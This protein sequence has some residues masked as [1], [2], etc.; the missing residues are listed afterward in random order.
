MAQ[1][2]AMLHALAGLDP[3]DAV[4]VMVEL[5]RE[6]HESQR[7]WRM[8]W[9]AVVATVLHDEYDQDSPAWRDILRERFTSATRGRLP[10]V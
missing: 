2:E 10:G 9:L 3:G 5:D 7:P 1:G 6:F 8:G 4:E